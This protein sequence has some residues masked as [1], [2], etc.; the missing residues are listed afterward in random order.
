MNIWTTII[1]YVFVIGGMIILAVSA[2]TS[3]ADGDVFIWLPMAIV[4]ISTFCLGALL[5]RR[6]K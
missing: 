1:A 5:M 6:N 4:G 3:D 2:G